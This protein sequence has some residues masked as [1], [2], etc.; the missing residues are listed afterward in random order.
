M[1]RNTRA[2]QLEANSSE[3][4]EKLGK[5][6][7][8][9]SALEGFVY[10]ACQTVGRQKHEE[11]RGT[12]VKVVIDRDTN[13]VIGYMKPGDLKMIIVEKGTLILHDH[14]INLGLVRR[15]YDNADALIECAEEFCAAYG[16]ASEF[17]ARMARFG[18]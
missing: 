13:V 15:V 16:C 2:L 9:K 17:Y 11:L 3:F 1:A 4:D 14:Q 7:R 5:L 8:L 10:M 6:K 12:K 18:V